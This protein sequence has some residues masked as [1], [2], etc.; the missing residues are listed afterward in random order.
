MLDAIFENEDALNDPDWA[1]DEINV[2]FL[3]AGGL[4]KTVTIVTT[5][6]S[7]EEIRMIRRQ[8]L[9][10][11]KLLQSIFEHGTHGQI[12]VLGLTVR[13]DDLIA[14]NIF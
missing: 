3:F 10:K 9:G 5:D 7:P 6:M 2:E 1:N 4:T 11:R 13:A 12:S 8:I 14:V